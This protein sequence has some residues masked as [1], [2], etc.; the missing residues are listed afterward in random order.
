MKN[1]FNFL[2]REQFI[3]TKTNL[4]HK[5][6]KKITISINAIRT[7]EYYSQKAS[8]LWATIKQLNI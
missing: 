2:E 8:R 4:F 6:I 3:K 5:N 1:Y 7:F